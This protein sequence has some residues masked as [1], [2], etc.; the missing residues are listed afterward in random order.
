M[1]VQL[2]KDTIVNGGVRKAG[3]I[4]VV[5]DRTG[6]KLER[7]WLAERVDDDWNDRLHEM[8]P[9]LE[10]RESGTDVRDVLVFVPVYRL[11]PETVKAVL[12]MEWDGA[13]SYLFQRD[14]PA[15]EMRDKL[16]RNVTNHLHQYK[17]GREAF[18]RGRYD[19]MLIVESDI[20]PPA[21][22]LQ[23]LAQVGTDVAYGVYRFRGSDIVNIFERYRD[24]NGIRARNIGESLSVRHSVFRRAV[25]MGVYPCSGAG[26]GCVLIKR[27]V[28]EQIEFRVEY[29]KN[30]SYCDSF[31]TEDVYRAG[32]TM[33]A[34][35]R[36]VCG[37][38]DENGEIL[39]PKMPRMDRT[40]MELRDES[41]SG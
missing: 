18:L 10:N 16:K 22:A 6:Y 36:V 2:T 29:P 40:A 33:A 41:Q 30:G 31:W 24:R 3:E 26:F 39:W 25:R 19:A 21:D 12:A 9:E 8:Y 4:I 13:I 27:K 23:R 35:M 28:L 14:N 15:P 34:D 20:I 32:F 1:I 37:H 38:K 5:D 11:E 7:R 17:R